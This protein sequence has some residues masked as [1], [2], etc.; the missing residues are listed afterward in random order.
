MT[1]KA[2][3]KAGATDTTEAEEKDPMLENRDCKR[4][5]KCSFTNTEL[6]ELGQ[7]LAKSN[8]DGAQAENEKTRVTKQLSATV[9]LHRT[10][11]LGLSRKI[12][13]G[14]E[15]RV[16]PCSQLLNFREGSVETIRLDT[17]ERVEIRAMSDDERQ[18]K[19][20]ETD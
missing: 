5:L 1:T 10:E 15:Y 14:Y 11:S 13:D 9:E 4:D 12:N 6:Q 16:V 17:H 7:K 8:A 2:E 20:P 3:K 18:P 19:L